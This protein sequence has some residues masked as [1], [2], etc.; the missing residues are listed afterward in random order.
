MLHWIDDTETIWLQSTAKEEQCLYTLVFCQTF[1]WSACPAGFHCAVC[2]SLLNQLA[3]C[4]AWSLNEY[5]MLC[6]LRHRHRCKTILAEGYSYQCPWWHVLRFQC[7][8]F[9]LP[10]CNKSLATV[11]KALFFYCKSIHCW[12][13]SAVTSRT[14]QYI[15]ASILAVSWPFGRSAVVTYAYVS[16]VVINA[17]HSYR[18]SLNRSPRL[19]R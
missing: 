11:P 14:S 2:L 10:Q 18:K 9:D 4:Q 16:M 17:L 15:W 5:V 8:R 7:Q 19:H 13:S 12:R 1:P 6:Y 3:F